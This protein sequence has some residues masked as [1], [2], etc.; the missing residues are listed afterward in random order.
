MRAGSCKY[1]N[2]TYLCLIKSHTTK[3]HDM[4]TVTLE[5]VKKFVSANE[6]ASLI[7]LKEA[8]VAGKG[9][10][11][12]PLPAAIGFHL[13]SDICQMV[14][15]AIDFGATKFGFEI[16]YEHYQHPATADFSLKELLTA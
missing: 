12:M 9:F 10:I 5:K 4:A 3:A 6:G 7:R 16:K 1:N 13:E 14:Q 8:W 2:P 15:T 11:Q